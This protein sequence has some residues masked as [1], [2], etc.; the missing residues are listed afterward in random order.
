[1]TVEA[2]VVQYRQ[3]MV[4]QIETKVSALRAMTTKEIVRNGNQA[5]FLVNGSG[6]DT[7]VSRGVNG[8]IP[9][10]NPTNTQ[11]TVT[12]VEKHAPYELTGFN[13]FASQGDQVA[14]MRRASMGVIN[15]EIDLTI[16]AAL[17]SASIDTGTS[18]TG[19]VDMV[20]KSLAE[21]GNNGVDISDEENLFGIITPSMLA[22]LRQTTEFSSSDYVDIKAYNGAVRK[23]LRWSGVNWATTNLISGIGTATEL[24]YIFHRDS[25]GY[26]INSGEDMISAGYDEKQMIS[27]S[28]ATLYHGAALLQNSGVVQVKHD[29]LAYNLS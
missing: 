25:I 26:A 19:S 18:A 4:D 6:T 2:A 21:L 10:G 29:G 13:V 14:G 15:R 22:Y 28:R 27:W 12:L 3:A 1:M 23:M 5:T 20:Q 8:L 11:T 24:C 17:A 9:F 7:A 16:L